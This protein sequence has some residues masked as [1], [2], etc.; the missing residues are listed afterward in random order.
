MTDTPPAFDKFGWIKAIQADATLSDKTFRLAVLIGVT[1][2]RKDGTGWAVELVELS[3]R[4]AGGLSQKRMNAA[5]DQLVDRGYLVDAGRSGGGRGNTARRSFHLRKPGTPASGVCSETRDASV[6][7]PGRW[8]T[9]PGTPASEFVPPDLRE[10]TPTGTSTGISTG[11]A[12]VAH[13]DP[14]PSRYCPDHPNDTPK[15]CNACRYHGRQHDAWRQ[16]QVAR[17]RAAI[18]ACDVCDEHG[19][20]DLGDSVKTCDCNRHIA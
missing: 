19:Q 20:I 8:R 11:V 1:Y 9:K 7:N 16:R 3:E 6:L 12:A 15:G 18:A 10:P 17:K 4:L 5:L 14:E 2:T 13:D